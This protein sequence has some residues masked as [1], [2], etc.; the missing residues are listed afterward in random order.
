M[1]DPEIKSSTQAIPSKYVTK[2]GNDIYA[3]SQERSTVTLHANAA[4]MR[5]E[6]VRAPFSA[7]SWTRAVASS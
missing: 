7:T 2:Q 6:N 5:H 1:Q 3:Y 4:L